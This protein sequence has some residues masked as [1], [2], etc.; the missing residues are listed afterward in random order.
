MIL[1]AAVE[2]IENPMGVTVHE[3]VRESLERI[4]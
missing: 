2:E 3:D 4:E 1:L